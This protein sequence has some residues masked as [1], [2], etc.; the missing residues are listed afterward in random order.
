[1]Q[2][3]NSHFLYYLHVP[4]K[5]FQ[6]FVG[7]KSVEEPFEVGLDSSQQTSKKRIGLR[8]GPIFLV[9]VLVQTLKEENV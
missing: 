2:R 6:N 5:Y 3:V 8:E 1:M 4:W 7:L 9:T